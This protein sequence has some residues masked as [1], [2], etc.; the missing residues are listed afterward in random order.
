MNSV[1]P[2]FKR[3]ILSIS[4]FC[5][6][7]FACFKVYIFSLAKALAAR[8][9]AFS[10]AS[11]LADIP[12]NPDSS[13]VSCLL[14]WETFFCDTFGFAVDV[15]DFDFWDLPYY[16]AVAELLAEGARAELASECIA[17]CTD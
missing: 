14:A 10:S 15:F 17:S 2:I 1:A 9:L 4:S 3:F 11:L 6:N 7:I 13:F 16:E 8:W 12:P 5:F